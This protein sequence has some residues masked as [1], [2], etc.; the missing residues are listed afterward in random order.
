[1]ISALLLAD[2]SPFLRTLVLTELMSRP[3]DDREVMELRTLC[4]K[5]PFTNELI[6]LQSGD[7]S[8]K[9]DAVPGTGG[10]NSVWVTAVMLKR[11]CYMGFAPEHPVIKKGIEYLFSQQNE[12]GAWYGHDETRDNAAAAEAAPV[13][14]ALILQAIV[15]C[16]YGNAPGAMKSFEWLGKFRLPEGAWSAGMVEGNYR[17]IAGYRRLAHSKFGCRSTT[18]AMAAALAY[19]PDLC[20]SEEAHGALDLILSTELKE[21]SSIGFETARTTGAEPSKGLLTYYARYDPAFI[22]DLCRRVGAGSNDDRVRDIISF[23]QKHR[24]PYGLWKYERNPQAARW[25][26]FDILRSLSHIDEHTDWLSMKPR[27]VFRKY[28]KKNKRY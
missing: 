2:P 6:A 24:G 18:T 17:G 9:G 8:W 27:I 19:H 15:F 3:S 4:K 12:C 26:T 16:G 11:L 22:L 20:K 28:P 10:T 14:T 1:M 13:F 25:I 5:D 23:L 21:E 7:G